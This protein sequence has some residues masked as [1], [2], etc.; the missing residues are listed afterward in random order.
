M[1]DGQAVV[2]YDCGAVLVREVG[3]VL[4]FD[5]CLAV[6]SVVSLQVASAN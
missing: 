2:V 5:E 4:N 6:Q 1:D 3:S